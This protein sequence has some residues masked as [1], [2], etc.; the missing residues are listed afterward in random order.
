MHSVCHLNS[1]VAA[2]KAE[3]MSEGEITE[4]ENTLARNAEAGELIPGT[5]GC[6]KLRLSGKGKGKRGGYRVITF[7]SGEKVPVFLLTVFSKGVKINL[8]QKER[9]A[10]SEL[11]KQLVEDYQNRTVSLSSYRRTGS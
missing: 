11:T 7:F 8:T 5:G 3:G 1:F 2:A 6:R 4:L 9:N 10:L